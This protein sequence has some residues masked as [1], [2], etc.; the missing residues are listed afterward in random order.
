MRN[1]LIERLSECPGIE[2]RLTRPVT[3]LAPVTAPLG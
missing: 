2:V 1:P 3:G